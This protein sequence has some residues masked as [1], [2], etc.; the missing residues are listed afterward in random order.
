MVVICNLCKIFTYIFKN[1]QRVLEL[2]RQ[3]RRDMEANALRLISDNKS[4]IERNFNNQ[5][6]QLNS[7]IEEINDK[8]TESHTV[9]NEITSKL[10]RTK[11][12]LAAADK[13][14]ERLK[15]VEIEFK[16]K[17]AEVDFWLNPII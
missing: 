10:D 2:E 12:E 7:I 14:I 11:T 8:L 17:M 3:D 9:N 15:N 4:K 5:I 16:S 13:E 1:I 6:Q